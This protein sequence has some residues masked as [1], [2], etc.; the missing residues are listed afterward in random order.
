APW[1]SPRSGV[2]RLAS[3]G[4]HSALLALALIPWATAKVPRV[5]LNETSVVL[6]DASPLKN[7]RL[8]IPRKSGGDSGGGGGGGKR[9]PLPASR[10]ELPRGADKQL[11]PPDP[12]PPKNPDPT[13]IVEPT[14]VA[15]QLASLRPVSLLNI[16][17]PNGVIAPPSSGRGKG[18]GIG[19][20]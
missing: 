14:I 10:G 16:G 3:V 4:I 6:Y 12:E 18:G 7:A 5:K 13:L 17:D 19:D 2:P 20:G 1:F 15:P 11:A 8:V 9:Q